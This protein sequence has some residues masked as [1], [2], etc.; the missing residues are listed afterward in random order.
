[1]MPSPSGDGVFTLGMFFGAKYIPGLGR[2]LGRGLREF[3]NGL[4]DFKDEIES[5]TF[6]KA[7]P[8]EANQFA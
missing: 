1:M 7:K 2:N 8:V 4:F 6:E 3:K 5:G